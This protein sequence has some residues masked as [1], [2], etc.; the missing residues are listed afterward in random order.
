GETKRV[1]IKL[2]GPGPPRRLRAMLGGDALAIDNEIT[3]LPL[4]HKPV[5]VDVQIADT[6]LRESVEKALNATRRA[7]ITT[8]GVELLLTDR[9]RAPAAGPQTWTVQFFAEQDAL[10]YI[11][12]FVID[13]SHPLAEGLALE[14]VVWAAGKT[15]RMPGTA[16]ISAGN[17]PLL[18]DKVHLNGRHELRI[19]LQPKLSTLQES[20]NWPVLIWN[21][22]QYRASDFPGLQQANLRLGTE[23]VLTLKSV[24]QNPVTVTTPDGR[25]RLL[26][27]SG[28]KTIIDAD[29]VGLFQVKTEQGETFTF[30]SNALCRDE[31]DLT[32]CTS[33]RWGNWLDEA[34]TRTELLSIAWLF[35][36]LAL[37]TLTAHMVLHQRGAEG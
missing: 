23:A 32:Q 20:P 28:K 3:L 15:E 7:L 19:R 27:A 5:R 29:D 17:V 14:G 13:R 10:A 31:S 12:P 33:G 8:R 35:L 11:G 30:A 26:R 2:W 25:V 21:L 22:L 34:A 4:K 16:V 24:S 1:M 9:E 37:A 6:E 36:L 18:S